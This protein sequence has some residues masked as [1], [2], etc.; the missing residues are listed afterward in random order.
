MN[1]SGYLKTLDGEEY[2]LRG[3]TPIECFRCGIRCQCYHPKI[4]LGKAAEITQKLGMDTDRFLAEY[5]QKGSR[6]GEL[7]SRG[8]HNGCT[9]LSWDEDGRARYE[10][11]PFRLKACRHFVASLP[12]PQCREGLS[13]E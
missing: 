4:T 8:S 11:Y 12:R 6:S 2:Q 3:M 13:V 5:V 10:I 9:F 7:V 1:T